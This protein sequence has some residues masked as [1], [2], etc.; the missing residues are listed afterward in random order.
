[1]A[2]PTSWLER[3]DDLLTPLSRKTTTRANVERLRVQL[4][5]VASLLEE[6]QHADATALAAH[7]RSIA[8]DVTAT[9]ARTIID[10]VT[11]RWEAVKTAV[12]VTSSVADAA[13]S[14]I[15]DELA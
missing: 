14:T 7:I 2:D 6:P 13:P 3:I 8:N 11:G 10:D 1:M 9:R 4:L 5:L 12:L 15:D